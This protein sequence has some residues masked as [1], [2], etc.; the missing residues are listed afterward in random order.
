LLRHLKAR[1]KANGPIT[2]AEYM[3]EVLINPVSGYYMNNDVFGVK[4]DFTTSPEISQMFGELIGIWCVNEYIQDKLTGTL[5][6]VEL[7]PG[8]GTLVD[9]MC[10]IFTNF[11]PL[12]DKVAMHL[13][14]VSP[15]LSGIQAAKLSGLDEPVEM[16][17]KT[18][19]HPYYHSMK[20]KYDQDVYWY[21]SIKDVPKDHM[22]YI[23]HEFFDALPIHKFQKSEKGWQEILVDIKDD[24]GEDGKEIQFVLSGRRTAG[25]TY[26]QPDANDTR[27]HI[28]V[29]P[30]SGVI[31]QEIC[32]RI[33]ENG[34]GLLIGD[35]GHDGT[36]TDTF[37]GFKNHQLH[38]VLLN[39]GTAD[40][41]ADVDFSYLRKMAEQIGVSVCGPKEQR[42][43]LINMGIGI[44]LQV[45]LQNVNA[46]GWKD[47]LS[48]YD[49]LINPD[50]MGQRFQFLGV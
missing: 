28:E 26:L 34:G 23:A 6:I 17:P 39:P 19:N 13:V 46:D 31:M 7:G 20:N 49:M 5:N 2:V 1:I 37:R 11:K 22:Y 9:D 45:L 35:Y 29:S 24:V 14:E 8:R 48:G 43:F 18:S 16:T 3:K 40:L 30:E 42:D 4:G 38:D 36:K 27:D 10:R 25:L 44:R 12:K 41:T 21:H 15:T 50:K 33:K 32:S 47:L